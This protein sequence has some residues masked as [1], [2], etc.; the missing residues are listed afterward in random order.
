MKHSAGLPRNDSGVNHT[1]LEFQVIGGLK[2]E[3]G[4]LLLLG[5]DGQ[6]YVYDADR[7]EVAMMTPGT[8]WAVDV[9]ENCSLVFEAPAEII[10]S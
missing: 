3:P 8:S 2:D 7:A 5:D 1:M 4:H 9:I 6:F 10:A